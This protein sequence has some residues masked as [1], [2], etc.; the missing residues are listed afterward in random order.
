MDHVSDVSRS[1]C[2]PII[3]NGLSSLLFKTT[4]RN[5]NRVKMMN[6]CQGIAFK[7]VPTEFVV[8][9]KTINIA[10]VRYL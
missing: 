8:M 5:G 2:R 9:F 3:S 10:P 1:S 4:F 6:I 7:N